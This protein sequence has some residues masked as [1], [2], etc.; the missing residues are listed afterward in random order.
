MALKKYRQIAQETL[1]IIDSNGYDIEDR[2]IAL[3]E[4]PYELRAVNVYTPE[5][6]LMAVQSLNDSMRNAV[7]EILV[8][9]LDS[10]ASARINGKGNV[11]VLN[12]ANSFHPGGG[13]LRGAVAQEEAICRCSSLYA[14][15]SSEQAKEMYEYNKAHIAPEGS[16]YMLLSSEVVV[17]RDS[18][19]NL[20]ELPYCISVITAAA[21]NLYDEACELKGLQLGDVMRH[22]IRNILAVAAQNNYDTL[23]LG[24]WG[25]GA[26]GHDAHD[27]SGY[28]YDVLVSENYRKFFDRIVFSIFARNDNDY[29]YREFA[30]RISALGT[31]Q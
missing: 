30:K 31:I 25:C 3:S 1:E 10:L 7:G 4:R 16:D 6:A 11:L 13:F 29:N 21:P 15:I 5:R 22:K 27:V 2:H 28:F 23:I 19:C 12:F 24:A 8:D 18:E 26:F 14:S 9:R 20:L 17:F